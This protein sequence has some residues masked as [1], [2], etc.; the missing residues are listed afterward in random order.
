MG[1]FVSILLS[2]VAKYDI[3]ILN[4]IN[5]KF[6]GNSQKGEMAIM[7]GSVFFSS[8]LTLKSCQ[9]LLS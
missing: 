5:D 4:K 9:N 3:Y 2:F 8:F 7:K 1:P 6:K